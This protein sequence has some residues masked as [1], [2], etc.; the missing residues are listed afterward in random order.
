MDDTFQELATNGRGG[1]GTLVIYS[2]G[3]SN[4]LITGFR[5]WAAHPNTMAIANSA[6]PDG[7]GVERKVNSSNFG[8]YLCAGR[9]STVA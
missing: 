3:N 1:L 9:R 7:G 5:T 2:A 6:Q 8:R 4:T